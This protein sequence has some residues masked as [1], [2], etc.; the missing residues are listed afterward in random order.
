MKNRLMMF[1]N[2]F[3]ILPV[4]FAGVYHEW[5]YC[6]LATGLLIFSPL[7]HWDKITEPFSFSFRLFKRLD[8]VF[9][10]SAFIYMYYYVYLH[11]LPKYEFVFYGLLSLVLLFFWYGYKKGD[12]GKIHPWFH[13]V[14]PIIS[15]AILIVAHVS[16][17]G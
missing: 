6:F 11:I 16:N 8:W 1:S 4:I 5:L 2:I 17:I 12:Y 14:A 7:Y 3:L 15:S 13:I 10:V 9:A